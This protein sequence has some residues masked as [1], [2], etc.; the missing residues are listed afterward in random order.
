MSS[1]SSIVTRT[2]DKGQTGLFGGMRVPK[3]HPRIQAC[4]D[5]D[6]LNA[7][8]GC[9][10]AEDCPAALQ[11]RL[12]R[13]QQ[14]LFR[15]GADIATPTE[16][17][18]ATVPRIEPRHVEELERDIATM[19]EILPSLQNFILPGGTKAAAHL[20]LARTICRRAERS[21]VRLAQEE[22]I[23]TDLRMFFNRVSDWLFLAARTANTDAGRTESAVVYDSP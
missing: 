16:H 10:L 7:A 9:A 1:L 2:G 21:L 22:P 14:L 5:T 4:G 13:M 19:E 11:E 17:N 3:D 15:A 6:E 18:A 20:H 23:G 12:L 8:L